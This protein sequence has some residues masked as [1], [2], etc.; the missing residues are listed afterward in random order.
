[1]NVFLKF[2]TKNEFLTFSN[3]F[4]SRK[5]L[6]FK[7]RESIDRKFDFEHAFNPI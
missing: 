2:C 5:I 3:R 6:P 1:M 4:A 7:A